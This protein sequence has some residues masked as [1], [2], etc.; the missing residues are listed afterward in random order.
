MGG[1]GGNNIPTILEL[2]TGLKQELE[3][4][5]HLFSYISNRVCE[6]LIQVVQFF[7][8]RNIFQ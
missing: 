8:V 5:Y 3:N 1:G 7:D 6:T 4:S 2:K